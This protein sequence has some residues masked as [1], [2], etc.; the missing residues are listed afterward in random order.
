MFVCIKIDPH[1][2]EIL[3]LVPRSILPYELL[4]FSQSGGAVF[5]GSTLFA[6][7]TS[8]IQQQTAKQF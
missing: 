6:K 4:V 1:Y 8:N 5:S 3:Y 2:E 7:E